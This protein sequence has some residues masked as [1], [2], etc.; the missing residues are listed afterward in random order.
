MATDHELMRQHV[1]SRAV[2]EIPKGFLENFNQRMQRAYADEF[3]DMQHRPARIKSQRPFNLIDERFYRADHELFEAAK[4]FGLNATANPLPQNAWRHVYVSC[5]E[6]GFTQSYVR[7]IGE[8]PKPAKFRES[9]ASAAKMPRLPLTEASDIYDLK[10]FYAIFTHCPIGDG[11]KEEQQ[12]LGSLMFSV[13]YE[14]MNEWMLNISV[15]ELITMYPVIIKDKKSRSPIWKRHEK[16]G[17]E[18]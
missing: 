1:I 10:K 12:R 18:E 14:D 7:R 13:P 8:M 5:G 2:A 17:G 9:L 4:D 11:F 16:K 6:F 15:S 3:A